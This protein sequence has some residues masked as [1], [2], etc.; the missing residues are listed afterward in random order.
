MGCKVYILSNLSDDTYQELQKKVPNLFDRFDGLIISGQIKRIKPDPEIY[1][2]L[3]ER[4]GL[5]PKKTV[6][7][8]DQDEN[9]E[10][11]YKVGIHPIKCAK[12]RWLC[13]PDFD[14]VR[15]ELAAWQAMMMEQ[16]GE[17]AE[18]FRNVVS[19]KIFA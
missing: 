13:G 10:A 12:G 1:H 7:I 14:R 6:F 4:F 3:L 15:S 2:C 5:D 11:A 17:A 18:S 9:L 19:G 8:D 16:T